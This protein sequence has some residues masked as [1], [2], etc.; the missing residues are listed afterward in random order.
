MDNEDPAIRYQCL[1]S[2]RMLTEKDLGIDPE[3][4]R[5]ELEPMLAPKP[6][7]PDPKSNTTVPEK[8]AASKP[9]VGPK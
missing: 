4:W 8:T 1:Q 7:V 2:L 6:A 3:A 9:L 5:R